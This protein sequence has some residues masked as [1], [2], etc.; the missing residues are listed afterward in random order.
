MF[1][2]TN[3]SN[4]FSKF[5]RVSSIL[6]RALHHCLALIL[7]HGN[8]KFIEG[9]CRRRNY[10]MRKSEGSSPTNRLKKPTQ[11]FQIEPTSPAAKRRE[12]SKSLDMSS[13]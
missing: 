11:C 12:N 4:K 3:K 1:A 2:V 13:S 5:S 9:R 10:N 8:M 7:G 6:S